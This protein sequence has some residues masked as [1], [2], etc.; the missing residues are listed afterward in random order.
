MLEARLVMYVFRGTALGKKGLTLRQ[1]ILLTL[2]RVA[3]D[4]SVA[5]AI[6]LN[7]RFRSAA[8]TLELRNLLLRHPEK[9][10]EEP[11]A[12]PILLGSGLPGDVSAQLKVTILH[13]NA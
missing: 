13:G 5:L 7:S 4:E 11:D 10:T 1:N 9:A 8:L 3:W 12:L 2:L 6:R